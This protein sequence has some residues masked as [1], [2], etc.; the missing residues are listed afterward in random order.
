M[1]TLVVNLSLFIVVF[2]KHPRQCLMSRHGLAK[3]G[4]VSVATKNS[5][6]RQG[7]AA[8]CH[9]NECGVTTERVWAG[10]TRGLSR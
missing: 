9:D 1:S 5:L 2:L 10:A 6:S 3:E 8:S 4:R 7:F